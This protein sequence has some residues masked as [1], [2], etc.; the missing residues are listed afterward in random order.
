MSDI[1]AG[2][3]VILVRTH[4][5]RPGSGPHV[6]YIF[7]VTGIEYK[8]SRCE[9]CGIVSTEWSAW[10]LEK[11]LTPIAWLKK[12]RPLGELETTER[13]EKLTA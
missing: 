1:Q 8:P 9:T 12:I 2:D 5:C 3:L 4:S 11:Y 7:K 6:G 10:G 13:E